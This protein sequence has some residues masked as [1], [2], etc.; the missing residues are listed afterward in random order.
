MVVI[1][2][3]H[4]IVHGVVLDIVLDVALGAVQ[5]IYHDKLLTFWLQKTKIFHSQSN[6]VSSH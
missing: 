6:V 5:L 1:G 4:C 2:V 3:V